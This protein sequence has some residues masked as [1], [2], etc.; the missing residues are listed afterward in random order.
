MFNFVVC[1][2]NSAILDRICEMLES[3]FVK[4]DIEATIGFKTNDAAKILSYI[5]NNSVNVFILDIELNSNMSGMDLAKRLRE[6]N[7]SAYIIFLTGHL[8]YMLVA[9]KVKTFDF[10]PKPI[11]FERLE[12]TIL[13]L[14]D[15]AS[16]SPKKYIRLGNK[17]TIIDQDNVYYIQKDGMKLIFHTES[18]AYEIYSSFNKIQSCLPGNF[19]RCHKSYIVNIDKVTDINPSNTIIFDEKKSCYIGPKYK[20]NFLEVFKN[21]NF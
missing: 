1:D 5:E 9:Y 14:I 20:N 15:D 2:D 13:R 12:E 17:N 4:H 18:R 6:K 10:L 7:K 21:G 11:T 19:V 3:I 16:N 8:E